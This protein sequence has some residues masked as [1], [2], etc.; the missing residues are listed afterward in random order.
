M[1]T[2]FLQKFI[3]SLFIFCKIIGKSQTVTV[4]GIVKDSVGTS[5]IGISV[6]DTIRKF[7]DRASKDQEFK[8][9]NWDRLSNLINDGKFFTYPDSIGNYRITVK[10]TDTLYFF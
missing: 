7:R 3:F 1:K 4:Q 10:I 6:N 2:R 8:D 9:K 5:G